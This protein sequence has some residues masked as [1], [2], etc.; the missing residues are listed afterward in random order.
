MSGRIRIS[1]RNGP[2]AKSRGSLQRRKGEAKSRRKDKEVEGS[3]SSN[4][5]YG[6]LFPDGR[7]KNP[8]SSP[9][10]PTRRDYFIDGDRTRTD[11]YYGDKA[12]SSSQSYGYSPQD[13]GGSLS[14]NS[15]GGYPAPSYG[16]YD[17]GGSPDHAKGAF[18]GYGH[19]KV[20][21]C[22][23]V[24][25]PLV[26]LALLGG[27]AA[28]TAFFNVL[29]TMNPPGKRRRRRSSEGG[30]RMETL[31]DEVWHKGRGKKRMLQREEI[32][33]RLSLAKTHYAGISQGS[34]IACLSVI[35]TKEIRWR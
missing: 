16:D 27:I 32:S 6:Y 11:P 13:G 33:G 4:G 29:I 12:R 1:V 7:G 14:Y 35:E 28:A 21:C 2:S 3:E 18:S 19:S 17:D 31:L 34:E 23:L 26:I 10:Y 5:Y 24:V 22:P 30:E 20:I 8:P 25:K 9:Y 15:R